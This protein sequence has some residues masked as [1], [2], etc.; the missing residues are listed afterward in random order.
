MDHEWTVHT[1]CVP[2]NHGNDETPRQA[3]S[4]PDC[5]G[6]GDSNSRFVPLSYTLNSSNPKEASKPK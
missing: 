1:F 2:Y 4:F 3:S 6:W 5:W